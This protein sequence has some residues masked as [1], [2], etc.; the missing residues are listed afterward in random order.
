MHDREDL[1]DALLA[2]PLGVAL[3]A[4]LDELE[5][6]SSGTGAAPPAAVVDQMPLGDLLQTAVQCVTVRVGPW[7]SEA[8]DV[9]AAAY[10]AAADRRPI[11][12]AVADRFGAALH[13]PLDV[14]RQQWWST[15]PAR[16]PQLFQAHDAVYGAGQ[17]PWTA[18]RTATEPPAA[19]HAQLIDSWELPAD[20]PIG[21]WWMPVAEPVRVLEIH[22]P[23]DWAALVLAHPRAAVADQE[24]WEL[25]GPHQAQV[26]DRVSRLTAI[27]GQRGA[28]TRVRRH[29][30]P[31]WRSVAEEYDAVHLSWAGLL[32]AEG[33]VTDLG[34]GDVAM[35]RY[36]FSERTMWLRDVFGEPE[37]APA[38]VLVDGA[39]PV[40]VVDVRRDLLRQQRDRAVLRQLLGRAD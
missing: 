5:G 8:P 25:P 13:E 21:R 2:A 29:L 22:R 17:L 9:V 39:G 16:A 12:E 38:P 33:C 34:D 4:A 20:A 6:S 19:L 27:P 32:T 26:H 31:D 24:W 11:A 28:R 18:L 10:E 35:L 37:P 30:V 15:E 7:I 23:S 3:L 14:T 36:W 1:V 40:P